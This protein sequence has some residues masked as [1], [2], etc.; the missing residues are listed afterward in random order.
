M[1]DF[2]KVFISYSHKTEKFDN[3]VLKFANKL[4]QDYDIDAMID[5]YIEA[6]AEGWPLWMERQ[7]EISDFVLIVCTK[8]YFEKIE[9]CD[10]NNGKGAIWEM[11]IVRQALYESYGLNSKFIPIV[12]DEYSIGYTPKPLKVTTYYNVSRVKDLKKLSTRILGIESNRKPP[13][14]HAEKFCS[15]DFK[16]H[17]L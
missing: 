13:V 4:R 12:F 8:S 15:F 7:I 5:Q 17:H 10:P 2:P 3:K 14:F 11:G 1:F 16:E 9:D 6:P